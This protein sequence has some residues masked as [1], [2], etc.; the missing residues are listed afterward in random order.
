M[1]T[2]GF[3]GVPVSVVDW[4]GVVEGV[5]GVEVW[6]ISCPDAIAFTTTLLLGITL[7]L[8]SALGADSG[9]VLFV[10]GDSCARAIFALKV[11]S[12]K[13]A[14]TNHTTVFTGRKFST[15]RAEIIGI[16]LKLLNTST[17]HKLGLQARRRNA[18]AL[19]LCS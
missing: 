6:A 5:A 18:I 17:H 3:T 15:Q 14:K 11:E 16:L 4:L 13:I 1:G 12:A 9:R 19:L 10:P 2:G 8:L 7:L